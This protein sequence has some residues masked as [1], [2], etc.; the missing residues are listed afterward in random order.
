MLLRHRKLHDW[1]RDWISAEQR[2]AGHRIT[3]SSTI[4]TLAKGI[5]GLGL[6]GIAAWLLWAMTGPQAMA[7]FYRL[8]GLLAGG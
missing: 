1:H 4:V 6:V 2:M 8:A 5:C 7:F 3:E